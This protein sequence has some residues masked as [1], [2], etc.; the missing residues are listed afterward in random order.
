[1]ISSH[2]WLDATIREQIVAV[3]DLK[4]GLAVHAVAGKRTAYQPIAIQG[5][6]DGDPFSLIAHYRRLGIRSLYIADLDSIL[7]GQPQVELLRGLIA[8]TPDFD[9]VLVDIGLPETDAMASF[10]AL[11]RQHPRVFV[12]AATECAT[13]VTALRRFEGQL[14]YSQVSLGMDYRD[15]AFLGGEDAEERWLE[16]AQP[17]GIERVVA[18]D[19]ATVGTSRGPSVAAICSRIRCHWPAV[20]LYSGGGIRD[21]SDV[22]L[23]Q[24][25]GCDRCLVATALLEP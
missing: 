18:L 23:L 13:G 9:E 20:K 5:E 7:Q 4:S 6:A 21:A 10:L 8:T 3:V 25:A 12:I 14:P 17:L 1:M 2:A 24:Q 15:G 19:M 16:F 11:A 22:K